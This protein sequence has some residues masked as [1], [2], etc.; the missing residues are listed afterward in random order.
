MFSIYIF[1][2]DF[3]T[4]N[5]SKS[6]ICFHN[7]HLSVNIWTFD[8]LNVK[9]NVCSIHWRSTLYSCTHWQTFQIRSCL[10]TLTFDLHCLNN[11]AVVCIFKVFF[12]TW[13]IHTSGPVE[14]RF[15]HLASQTCPLVKY[16][17]KVIV[18]PWLRT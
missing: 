17:K 3:W 18:E 14:V 8:C 15:K 5:I 9:K 12:F 1:I 16:V 10:E 2:H 13:H 4:E 7:V 6:G 11:R